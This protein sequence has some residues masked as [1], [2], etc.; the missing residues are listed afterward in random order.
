VSKKK[1]N[2]LHAREQKL[3]VELCA[4]HGY[5]FMPRPKTNM[6][7]NFKTRE[8]TP[9]LEYRLVVPPTSKLAELMPLKSKRKATP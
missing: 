5:A 2:K 9:W 7:M 6:T 4:K 8:V 3:L 1:P